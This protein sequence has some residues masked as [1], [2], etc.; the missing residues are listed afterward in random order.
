MGIS[1]TGYVS[2]KPDSGNFAP[3]ILHSKIERVIFEQNTICLYIKVEHFGM[4]IGHVL[5]IPL[6]VFD[7]PGVDKWLY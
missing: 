1:E 7:G 6:N 5:D 2:L 3:Y 4:V